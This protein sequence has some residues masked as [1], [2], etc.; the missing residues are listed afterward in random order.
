MR[1][2]LSISLIGIIPIILL[3]NCEKSNS[4]TEE[5]PA[6][7]LVSSFTISDEMVNFSDETVHF[8]AEF[9]IEVNWRI[10]I[11]GQESL[12][13]KV[14]NG[15][16]NRIN[17]SNSEWFGEGS[18]L[19]FQEEICDAKL[20]LL[21]VPDFEEVVSFSIAGVKN[22][23][24][25]LLSDFENAE[26]FSQQVVL[27]N[28]EFELSSESGRISD[29]KVLQGS[30]YCYLEGVDGPPG[31]VLENFFVGLFELRPAPGG[32]PNYF[33]V[34]SSNPDELYFNCMALQP[35]THSFSGL[36]IDFYV[37]SNNDG[38]FNHEEDEV[39]GFSPGFLS[40]Q[41]WNDYSIK[42]SDIGMDASDVSKIMNINFAL[43]SDKNSQPEPPLPV[44]IGIDYVAFSV[45][46][47]IDF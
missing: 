47:P 27:R 18:T 44:G 45:G 1:K 10:V 9:N 21:D 42:L 25:F 15:S 31:G 14:I 7:Q 22:H 28:Y 24:G 37:D 33:D 46:A 29:D 36:N 2:I 43:L 35:F 12:A 26:D 23:S 8:N 20:I 19:I 34:P 11:V 4:I 6:P 16:G 40:F 5:T 39:F 41:G 17:A 3:T 32:F 30:W 38:K 13:R